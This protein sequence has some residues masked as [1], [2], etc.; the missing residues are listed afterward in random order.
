LVVISVAD[1]QQLGATVA[2]WQHD[3]RVR[4]IQQGALLGLATTK[5]A[6]VLALRAEEVD[7]VIANVS[8]G[9]GNRSA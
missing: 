1:D 5:R 7:A 3:G 2:R 6:E 8:D 9:Q 4:A